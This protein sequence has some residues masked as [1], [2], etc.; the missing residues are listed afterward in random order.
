M[1]D[2]ALAELGIQD[3]LEAEIF[4]SHPNRRASDQDTVN[5]SVASEN[6][7][8]ASRM[9]FIAQVK[10]IQSN[11]KYDDDNERIQLKMQQE[12]FSKQFKETLTNFK[13]NMKLLESQ[14]SRVIKM[15]DDLSHGSL[16]TSF[17]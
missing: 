9:D 4:K 8:Y 10:N 11:K 7:F 3:D 2:I 1:Q 6:P 5:D 17:N 13:H 15:Q 12:K 14:S 16:Q